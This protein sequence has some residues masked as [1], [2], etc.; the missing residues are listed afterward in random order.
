MGLIFLKNWCLGQDSL[1]NSWLFIRVC[2]FSMQCYLGYTNIQSLYKYLKSFQ[3]ALAYTPTGCWITLKRKSFE[4]TGRPECD[5]NRDELDYMLLFI[6]LCQKQKPIY[7][8][9]QPVKPMRQP[10]TTSASPLLPSKQ[11]HSP[12]HQPTPSISL[13]KA[14]CTTLVP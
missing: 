13:P 6:G 8:I 3:S 12:P 9:H 11:L 4:K 2:L 10:E 5:S 7:S 1:R 14:P